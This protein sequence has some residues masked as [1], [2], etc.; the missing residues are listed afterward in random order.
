MTTVV[1][2]AIPSNIPAQLQY[3]IKIIRNR[4]QTVYS[5]V[6]ISSK[7]AIIYRMAAEVLWSARYLGNNR[8]VGSRKDIVN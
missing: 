8:L 6:I 5:T 2:Y 3:Y 7:G 4:L 1:Y